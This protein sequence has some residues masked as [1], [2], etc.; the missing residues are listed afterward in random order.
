MTTSRTTTLRTMATTARTTGEDDDDSKDGD[1]KD[2]DD[3]KDD[4]D[5]GEDDNNDGGNDDSSGG[6]GGGGDIG[7]QVGGV[8]RS[9]YL[10][11]GGR[12]EVL[13]EEK[14]SSF[15][16]F[17][18]TGLLMIWMTDGLYPQS[19][20]GRLTSIVDLGHPLNRN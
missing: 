5:I 12:S 20:G 8:A 4:S 14:Y 13:S 1:S 17:A 2:D 9:C 7:G 3:S 16:Y 10:S 19:K 6:G 15:E 18:P 11:K